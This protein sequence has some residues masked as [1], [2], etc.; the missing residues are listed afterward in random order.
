MNETKKTCLY[1]N[2]VELG[3]LMSPFGGYIMPIQYEGIEEEHKSVRNECGVFDVSHMGEVN[4]SGSDAERYVNY[5][6][7][8]DIS[9]APVG[10]IF[11]GMMLYENGGTV[12][13][14]LVYKRGENNFL[15]VINAS[16]IDKDVEWITRHANG[17][18]VEI[19]DLSNELGELAV[20]GPKAE[21]VM[22]QVLG[23]S[24]KELK[25]YTFNESL[26]DGVH[27]LVSRTGYT[28]EDGFE[29]YA[30]NDAIVKYW[31]LLMDSEICKP[32]GLGCRDTLR[33][34]VALPLYGHE[35][36]EE[37]TP[38]MS[39]LSTFVKFDKACGFIGRDSLLK[40]KTEGPDKKIVG[41]ELSDR[42]IAR[43]GYPVINSKGET[44]G[45]ITTGYRGISIDKSLALALID[46]KYSEKG[47]Q[48]FVK[49]RKKQFPATVV[50]K[51][52]YKKNYK[53]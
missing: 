4:I 31:N 51:K 23:I 18:D 46:S 25:F 11:Y 49:I 22:E 53:Q 36:S 48:V 10:Q 9:N 50:A 43:A 5:I 19:V 28:G 15:L 44:I 3:A 20:Q 1:D 38:V 2:H 34:E 21:Y 24:C 13:D 7:T 45:E 47:T 52:F 17:Y 39:G 26:L 27:I 6:F 30:E 14:L 33:F 12:D 16:N 41:I 8:N 40:Q 35:L 32:C 42:A 29:I 37:I